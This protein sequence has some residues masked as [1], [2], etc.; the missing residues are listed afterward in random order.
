MSQHNAELARKLADAGLSVFPCGPDKRPLV[1]WRTQSSCDDEAITRWWLQF[2]GALPGIDLEKCGLLAL[3]G[4]RHGGPDGRAALRALLQ[5]HGFE[6]REAPT[7]RTPRGGVHVYFTLNGQ[8]LGN[9]RGAL[10]DG[11]DV[12]ARGGY[13]IGPGAILPDGRCYQ[14]IAGTPDLATA[15]KAET[16]PNVPDAIAA[17]LKTRKSAAAEDATVP[18]PDRPASANEKAYAHAALDG[19]SDELAAAPK[20]ERNHRLNVVAFRLGRMIGRGWVHRTEVELRLLAAAHRNGLAAEG[21]GSARATI[22]SGINAGLQQPYRDLDGEERCLRSTSCPADR[23]TSAYSPVH[24][25]RGACRLP[26][27]AGSRIRHGDARRDAVGSRCR[28]ACR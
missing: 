24:A 12:R 21:E 22:A 2:P 5:Q 18:R 4:D 11:I 1:S 15:Y 3:D 14:P 20:G 28:A 10:P 9:G 16:I 8:D 7:T 6:S 19:C 27:M 17:L 26:K 23:G 25:H 13:V